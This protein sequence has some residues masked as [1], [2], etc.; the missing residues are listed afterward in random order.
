MS[1]RGFDRF[2]SRTTKTIKRRRL[3]EDGGSV[4]PIGRPS[5]RVEALALAVQ[6][7]AQSVAQA[8]LRHA[9]AQ[10]QARVA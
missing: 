9:A 5:A 8:E 6:T 10:R 3:Y 2:L 4:E 7:S 1:R